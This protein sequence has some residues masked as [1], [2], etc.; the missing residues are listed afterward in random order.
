ML[1]YAVNARVRLACAVFVMPGAAAAR[2]MSMAEDFD[3]DLIIVGCGVGGHGAA[4]HARSCGERDMPCGKCDMLCARIGMLG[5]RFVL[6]MRHIVL[7]VFAEFNGCGVR[8]GLLGILWVS[9][10]CGVACEI[11]VM[12]RLLYSIRLPS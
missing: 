8:Y 4:L 9:H 5:V 1:R 2:A 7:R 11:D 10:G 6:L 12:P 3:Y